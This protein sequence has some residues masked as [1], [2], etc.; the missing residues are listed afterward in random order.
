MRRESVINRARLHSGRVPRVSSEMRLTM[1]LTKEET[2][3]FH[4]KII[5]T[6]QT[7]SHEIINSHI[8]F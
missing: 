4:D 5:I 2:N 1:L 3:I 6:I 7:H 8:I